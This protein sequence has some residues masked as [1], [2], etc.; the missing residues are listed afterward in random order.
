MTLHKHRHWSHGIKSSLRMP[1][2][3]LSNSR[4]EPDSYT[5]NREKERRLRQI[6]KGS[7]KIANGLIA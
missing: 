6:K 1:L 5:Q 7:L 3:N 4:R 2:M